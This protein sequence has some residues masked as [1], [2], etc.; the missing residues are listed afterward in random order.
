LIGLRVG[1]HAGELSALH[2]WDYYRERAQ[3]FDHLSVV[4]MSARLGFGCLW[5]AVLAVAGFWIG[6]YTDRRL[7][8][9][10]A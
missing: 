7:R 6:S 8:A 1:L 9:E 3:S 10:G 4:Y 5:A 2:V